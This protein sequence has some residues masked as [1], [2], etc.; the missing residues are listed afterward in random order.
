MKRTATIANIICQY[1]FQRDMNLAKDTITL[2][3][4]ENIDD[5]KV[6][7]SWSPAISLLVSR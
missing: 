7:S 6:N 1:Q 5:H 4:L 3:G 2:K